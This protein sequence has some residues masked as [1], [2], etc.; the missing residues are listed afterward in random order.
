MQKIAILHEHL[1]SNFVTASFF[2]KMM[3]CLIISRSNPRSNPR[4]NFSTTYS[5]VG[6]TKKLG[7]IT[8]E[9]AA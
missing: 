3:S 6:E 9:S 5:C 8:K 4:S 1:V 2:T 7:A